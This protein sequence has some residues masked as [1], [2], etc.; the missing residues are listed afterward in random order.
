MTEQPVSHRTLFTLF[1]IPFTV[2]SRSWQFVPPKLV[3]GVAVAF[4]FLPDEPAGYRLLWGLIFGILLVCVLCLHILGHI[5][6]SKSV[7]PPMTEAFITPVLI[8]THYQADPENLPGRI[9]LI[10]SLG[11]PIMNLVIGIIALLIWGSIGGYA[12]LFFAGANFVILGMVLLPF[13]SVDGEVIWREVGRMM[14]ESK[15]TISGGNQ[16]E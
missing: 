3:I 9:H 11:G 6:S 1:G 4:I 5:I 10:R 8:E 2:T 14:R 15:K 7:S 16:H 13:K 12:L